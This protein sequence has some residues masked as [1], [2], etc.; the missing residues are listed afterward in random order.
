VAFRLQNEDP[1]SPPQNM[2]RHPMGYQ[3]LKAILYS[4][5]LI[6]LAL[7]MD[8]GW[9]LIAYAHIVAF[10]ILLVVILRNQVKRSMAKTM[11][12]VLMLFLSIPIFLFGCTHATVE[13]VGSSKSPQNPFPLLLSSC[14]TLAAPMDNLIMNG[15]FEE[16]ELGWTIHSTGTSVTWREHPLIGSGGS[17]L[18][19]SGA[20]AARLGGHEGSWDRLHQT[21]VIPSNGLLTYW[22]QIT[23]R[24]HMSKLSVSLL[25]LDG[26]NKS[27]LIVHTDEDSIDGWQKDCIDLS[28]FSGQEVLL[29]FYVKNDNY[30]Q[31]AFDLDDVTLGSWV[32]E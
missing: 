18:P 14:P 13:P 21:V 4:T 1:V 19:H 24:R 12:S 20:A 17:F 27:I 10:A 32:E 28:I 7:P 29:E 25:E 2:V 16:G 5:T 31:T 23:Q 11:N 8:K 9:I 26:S 6:I 30:T 15:G 3:V 22:W